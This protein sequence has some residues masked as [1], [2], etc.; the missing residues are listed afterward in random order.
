MPGFGS[1][2]YNRR[3]FG[4][5]VRKAVEYGSVGGTLATFFGPPAVEAW[6][7]TGGREHTRERIRLLRELIQARYGVVVQVD[8]GEDL[9]HTIED[10]G[11]DVKMHA[12]RSAWIQER[13]LDRLRRILEKYP[14]ELI[15]GRVTEIYLA[16]SF[17]TTSDTDGQHTALGRAGSEESRGKLVITVP[18]LFQAHFAVFDRALSAHISHHEIAH[19]LTFDIPEEAWRSL[20]NADFNYSAFGLWRLTEE[21]QVPQGFTDPYAL[22]GYEEDIAQV[23]ALIFSENQGHTRETL[24][25]DPIL[26][27]KADFIK[28]WYSS[29]APRMNERY[30]EDLSRGRINGRYWDSEQTPS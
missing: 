21:D 4:G 1:N 19:A 16:N 23:A 11:F 22:A 12:M 13:A 27:R 14:P 30:W 29:L 6:W 15:K 10:P 18:N 24:D 25:K 20:N 2:S 8:F 17:E 26:K 3:E 28:A 5:V 9:T 7:N